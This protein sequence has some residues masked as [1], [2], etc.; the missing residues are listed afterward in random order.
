MEIKITLEGSTKEEI[1]E[2]ALNV[3]AMFGAAAPTA[4]AKVAAAKTAAA[5]TTAKTKPAPEPEPEVE[6]NLDLG[7]D[8]D[9][10][11]AADAIDLE[12][13]QKGFAAFV[14]AKGKGGMELAKKILAK[15]KATSVKDLHESKYAAVLAELEK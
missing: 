11:D 6:E 10:A 5:K 12:Q 4:V 7:F 3:L 13:M 15:H 1:A 9:T 2:K 14:K 8:V